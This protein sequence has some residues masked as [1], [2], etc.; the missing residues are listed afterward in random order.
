MWVHAMYKYYFVN[1]AV[2]PKKAALKQANEELAE[3]ERALAAARAKMQEVL[4]RLSKLQTQL[5]AKIAFKQEKEQSIAVCEERMNRA[6]RL[7]SGLADERV[8]Y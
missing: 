7:I 6:V 8:R 3:T 2:A 5:N 4:D 1:L